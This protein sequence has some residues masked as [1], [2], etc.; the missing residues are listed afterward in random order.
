MAA[1]TQPVLVALHAVQRG[2]G[3]VRLII[4]RP[5][6]PARLEA[7]GVKVDAG[8]AVVEVARQ[9]KPEQE[10]VK[11][12]PHGIMSDDLHKGLAARERADNEARLFIEL[13]ARWRMN[14]GPRI[15]R[16]DV[17]PT[18]RT[19]M[20]DHSPTG[21]AV[22]TVGLLRALTGWAFEREPQMLQN[23][24]SIFFGKKQV[25]IISSDLI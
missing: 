23:I 19:G 11:V 9:L 7:L 13:V 4:E 1:L 21:V 18:E 24:N 22:T 3:Q 6:S 14:D 17:A 20:P 25:N 2:V 12:I 15:Q 8:T 10:E 16:I 5:F